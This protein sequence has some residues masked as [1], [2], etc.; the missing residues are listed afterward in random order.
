MHKPKLSGRHKETQPGKPSRK[1]WL[2]K[3]STVRNDIQ[4]TADTGGK[5]CEWDS[6]TARFASA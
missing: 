3:D 4:Y 5:E 1:D 6:S 2:T